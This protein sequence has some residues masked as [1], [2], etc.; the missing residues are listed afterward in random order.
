MSIRYKK[1]DGSIITIPTGGSSDSSE[2]FGTAAELEEQFDS[3]PNGTKINILDDDDGNTIQKEID[4]INENLTASDN[5]KFRFATDGEGNYGF[6]GA[7]GSLIPF[8]SG[9]ELSI[10][11]STSATLAGVGNDYKHQAWFTTNL[12]AE[13]SDGTIL[14]SESITGDTGRVRDRSNGSCSNS[15]TYSITV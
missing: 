4:A 10:S 14:L 15:G 1:S 2:W 5:L 12:I 3:I 9:E 7:D 6:L 13:K 11:V 8:K